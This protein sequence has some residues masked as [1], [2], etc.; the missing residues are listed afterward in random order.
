M[1]G[2]APESRGSVGALQL[3]SL[4]TRQ[5]L[6]LHSPPHP[7]GR[8]PGNGKLAVLQVP[9]ALESCP[10]CSFPQPQNKVHCTAGTFQPTESRRASR[11]RP[12]SCAARLRPW[13]RGPRS[14]SRALPVSVTGA[15]ADAIA[16]EEFALAFPNLPDPTRKRP[17]DAVGGADAEDGVGPGGLRA[18]LRSPRRPGLAAPAPG[19]LGCGPEALTASLYSFI[20]N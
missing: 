9:G 5:L 19:A 7:R 4:G 3:P 20:R 8:H 12:P 13:G 6:C 1:A 2:L 11:P 14:P 17:K 18:E 15:R 16:P 10:R